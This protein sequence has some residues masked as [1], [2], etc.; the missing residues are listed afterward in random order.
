MSAIM[1]HLSCCYAW[2]HR[3]QVYI[4]LK[5]RKNFYTAGWAKTEIESLFNLVM[6]LFQWN[7]ISSP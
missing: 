3:K 2:R 4:Q 7:N 1:D 5:S 6:F